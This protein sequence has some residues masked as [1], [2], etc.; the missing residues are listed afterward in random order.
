MDFRVVDLELYQQPA[1]VGGEDA[2][3]DDQD[4]TGDYTTVSN[5]I[6]VSV[7]SLTMRRMTILVSLHI[8]HRKRRR[9]RQHA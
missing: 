6:Y 8:H 9:E 3:E 2:Q 5:E 1:G 4:Y 7:D